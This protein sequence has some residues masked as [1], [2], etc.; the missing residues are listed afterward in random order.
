MRAASTL[1]LHLVDVP[2]RFNGLCVSSSRSVH[3]I[4]GKINRLVN[5]MHAS[6]RFTSLVWCPKIAND[7]WAMGDAGLACVQQVRRSSI[8]HCIQEHFFTLPIDPVENPLLWKNSPCMVLP[9]D[10]NV[11]SVRTCEPW[12]PTIFVILQKPP[13]ANFAKNILPVSSCRVAN[14]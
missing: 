5:V 14:R 13:G 8:C 2:G 7:D 6:Y 10:I 4:F 11:S 12:P 3:A 9:R 1:I